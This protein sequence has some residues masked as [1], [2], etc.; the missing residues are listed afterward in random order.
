MDSTIAG[1]LIGAAGGAI[2]VIAT[3]LVGKAGLRSTEKVSAA[4]I[5]AARDENLRAQDAERAGRLWEQ[6]GAVY[7]D[8]IT[9]IRHR[10]QARAS[11]AS[12]ILVSP[13]GGPPVSNID[14]ANLESR[15]LA[16][17]TE[18]VI[19]A[20]NASSEADRRHRAR[21][22]LWSM[23]ADRERTANE[24]RTQ[25]IAPPTRPA[26]DPTVAAEAAE[27]AMK[28]ATRLDDAVIDMIRGE[29]QRR[30]SSS[31][32]GGWHHVLPPGGNPAD[33]PAA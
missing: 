20:L 8:A 1:A 5:A 31:P 29:L 17:A 16:F 19:G 33:T 7:V 10:Q 12:T 9:A 23:L 30:P 13:S 24:M 11:Q 2:G 6:R 25:G 22:R 4:G 3:A 18:E 32:E 21:Y 14:W 27:A 15:L 28:D 26:R